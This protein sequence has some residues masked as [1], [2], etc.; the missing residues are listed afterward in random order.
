M[1]CKVTGVR[2]DARTYTFAHPRWRTANA[3]RKHGV[4]SP[5]LT[6]IFDY[7]LMSKKVRV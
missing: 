2:L 6:L 7:K 1:G 4:I 3:E 5:I